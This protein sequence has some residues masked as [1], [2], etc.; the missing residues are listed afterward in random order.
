MKKTKKLTW[1]AKSDTN[2]ELTIQELD[3]I[4]T[5]EKI[6]ENDKI[7]EIVNRNSMVEYKA[8][9]EGNV[10]TLKKGERIQLTRRG[11]FIVDSVE[12]P[13]EPGRPMKLIF[14]PDGKQKNMSTITSAIDQKVLAKGKG[15]GKAGA[16][17]KATPAAEEGADGEKKLS[18]KEL[19]KLKKKE[20]R[21]TAIAAAK[22]GGGD[23][24]DTGAGA[25][26]GK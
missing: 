23:Q 14:I 9:A 19:N 21:A 3:H 10:R 6:E 22:G 20:G 11:Y 26:K 24:I 8:I 4:I 5:K 1:V 7:E 12:V 17:G 2:V 16:A 18:K 13:G 25:S 15:G